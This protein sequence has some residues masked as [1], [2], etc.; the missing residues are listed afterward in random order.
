M[1]EH[2]EDVYATKAPENVGWYE[3]EPESSL[4]LVSKCDIRKDDVILDVG[5][6]A[7]VFIDRLLELG[8]SNITALDISDT[9]LGRLKQRLAPDRVSAVTWI[10]GD[11]TQPGGFVAPGSVSLWHDRALLHFFTREQD[12][13][14]YLAALK[15]A[16]RAGGYVIIGV[17]SLEGAAR[18]SGLELKRYD[19]DMLSA[20]LGS[21]FSLIDSFSHTH[22]MP[23]GDPRPYIYAL[24]RR[25]A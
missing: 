16:V 18:C 21:G 11:I 2:W 12:Q 22:I 4:K 17:F 3:S 13:N 15:N 5:A 9:A 7:S 14:A 25:N 20:F 24:F 23:S 19:R 10:T 8:F 6:G 1:K